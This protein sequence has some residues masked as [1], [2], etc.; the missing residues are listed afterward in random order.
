[1][2]LGGRR[3]PRLNCY[4]L[5][6]IMDE[7]DYELLLELYQSKNI[8][9]TAQ[10]L[11][12]TQPAITKRLQKME[13]ELQCQLM[14]RSKR[15]VIFTPAGESIIPYATA[16][17]TNIRLLRE[18]AHASQSDI[19]GT[20][21]LGAS[22][23]FSHYRLPGILKRFTTRYPL[24]DVQIF[25]GQSRNLYQKLLR[26]ELSIA[27]LRGEYSWEDPMHLLSSE[28]MCLVC[29][30]DNAGRPLSEYPYIGRHT[31][32]VLT[33]K[34]QDWMGRRGLAGISPKIHVDDID[35]C[36]EMTRH[37]L[38]WCILPRICLDDFD[39]YCEE[40]LLADGTPFVRNTYVLYKKPYGHL[41]QIRMF[42]SYLLERV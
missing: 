21:H 18:Q 34:I 35:T 6:N 42:L 24:V 3:L 36:K 5:E 23:N 32:P 9:K 4:E 28:P 20:I 40:L 12:I 16:I 29:S 2:L 10:K 41:P 30:R 7:K 15:G 25:T 22:L 11:F 33:G 26:D 1:M 37:G 13:E 19:C 17:L 27:I 38:G 8:T 14:I 31:D 39:G